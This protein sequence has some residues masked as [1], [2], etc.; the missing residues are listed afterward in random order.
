MKKIYRLEVLTF[1]N[2]PSN[3]VHLTSSFSCV[4]VSNATSRVPV[5]ENDGNI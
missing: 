4:T 3:S 1:C 5:C 2:S